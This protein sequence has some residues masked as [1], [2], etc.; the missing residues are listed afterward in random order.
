MIIYSFS[1]LIRNSEMDNQIETIS[2]NY[3]DQEDKWWSSFFTYDNQIR[4]LTQGIQ[5]TLNKRD[6]HGKVTY[7]G[8]PCSETKDFLKDVSDEIPSILETVKCVV[9]NQPHLYYSSI[10]FKDLNLRSPENFFIPCMD[11]TYFCQSRK[12]NVRDVGIIVGVIMKGDS[13]DQ[14]WIIK[15]SKYYGKWLNVLTRVEQ[16]VVEGYPFKAPWLPNDDGGMIQ[17]KKEDDYWTE[18]ESFSL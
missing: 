3:L 13:Q 4:N 1:L 11:M 2:R 17:G 6:F 7:S 15:L 14:R 10:F 12:R 9:E 18:V 5:E 8:N 16:R